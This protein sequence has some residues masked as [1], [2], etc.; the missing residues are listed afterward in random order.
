VKSLGQILEKGVAVYFAQD[1][2][3]PQ[4]KGGG[5]FWTILKVSKEAHPWSD[6]QM[7]R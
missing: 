1:A 2:V 7:I 5:K 6:T 3:K 4:W